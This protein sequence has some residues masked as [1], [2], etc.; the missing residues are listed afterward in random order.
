MTTLEMIKKQEDAKNDLAVVTGYIMYYDMLQDKINGSF[1]SK[2]DKA[3]E[4][5]EL[6]CS[7]YPADFQWGVEIDFEETLKEFLNKNI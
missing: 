3:I 5:A 6:F 7:F 1:F 4:I 2:I